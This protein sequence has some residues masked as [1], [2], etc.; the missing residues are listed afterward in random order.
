MKSNKR[1][2]IILILLIVLTVAFPFIVNADIFLFGETAE[3]VVIEHKSLYPNNNGGIYSLLEFTY[4]GN[5][6]VVLSP[7]NIV[8]PIGMKKRIYFHAQD[9]YDNIMLSF[10]HLYASN[11]MAIPL[12]ILIVHGVFSSLR[13]SS[14]KGNDVFKQGELE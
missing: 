2:I 3:G 1:G 10:V 13:K 7:E 9:P 14:E 5:T 12:F 4:E 8:Y 11:Y 6:V